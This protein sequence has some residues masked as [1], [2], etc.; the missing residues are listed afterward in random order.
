VSVVEWADHVADC[1]PREHFV[2]AI[3]VSGASERRF[4][5]TANGPLCS[6]RLDGFRTAV[7]A[8]SG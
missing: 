6:A 2:L 7:A 1:L 4:R 5:L 8:W 3:T